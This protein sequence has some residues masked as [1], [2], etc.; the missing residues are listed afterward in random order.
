MSEQHFHPKTLQKGQKFTPLKTKQKGEK[1]TSAGK[2]HYSATSMSIL[3]TLQKQSW[4]E[5]I[6]QS[7]WFPD[8]HGNNHPEIKK[9]WIE[10]CMLITTTD[11]WTCLIHKYY[12][13]MSYWAQK[14]LEDVCWMTELLSDR[15]ADQKGSQKMTDCPTH[16]TP[17]LHSSSLTSQPPSFLKK[18]NSFVTPLCE[19]W[20][21][22]WEE[23][24]IEKWLPHRW[25]QVQQRRPSQEKWVR[26][27]AEIVWDKALS[28]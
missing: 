24:G 25:L 8:F 5:L 10:K 2:T 4:A 7:W 16:L 13:K 21:V 6:C 22:R 28:N 19:L 14:L 27:W 1:N 9:E 20:S 23:T 15:W 17:F 11:G 18:F 26:N 3:E 12:R